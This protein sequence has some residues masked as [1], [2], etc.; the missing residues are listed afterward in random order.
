VTATATPDY[1]VAI[2]G[3]GPLGLSVA[4][5]LRDGGVRPFICGKPMGF[6]R[7]QMPRGMLLRS[8]LRASNIASPRGEL[9]LERW[10]TVERREASSPLPV[11]DFIAY[12]EWF[13][14]AAADDLD[15]RA[16]ASI[17]SA[18]P[19]FRLVLE[20]GDE[21]HAERVVV[22]AGIAH[23]AFIPPQL[24]ALPSSL[25][26]HS[27]HH[28]DFAG[29]AGRRVAVLGAGQSAVES[30]ALLHEAGAEVEL[31]FRSEGILW[32]DPQPAWRLPK[33]GAPTAVGGPRA[34]WVV[35]APD[36]FRRLPD[37]IQPW[38]AYRCIRPAASAWL[39][40]R[41][42]AVVTT[43]GRTIVA[44]QPRDE[45]LQLTLSDGAVRRVDHLLLATGFEVDVRQYPFLG[46]E[47]TQRLALTGG[48]PVL[49][50][51]LESSIDGL[52]FVGAPA[53]RTFG[54]V[55]R[56]VTGSSYAAPAVAR[57]VLGRRQPPISWAF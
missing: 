12:G 54:P 50:P 48:Y 7:E 43:G 46:A 30:S 5:Y 17:E 26:S 51:G 42:D 39:H 41:T 55:M 33:M 34:S 8:P 13:Q 20:G 16:V 38:L 2:V 27:S 31:I 56:F 49:R 22:A 3:A 25:V 10:A 57:R 14:R 29:F 4:A 1:E 32:L 6:W 35:A 15:R 40:T 23:F 37:A 44:A 24:S 21:L 11:E 45:H 47:L 36:V 9:A 52:H 53:A 19:R 28:A 18:G